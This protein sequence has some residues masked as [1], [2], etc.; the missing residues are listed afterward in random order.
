MPLLPRRQWV[1]VYQH[2][3]KMVRLEVTILVFWGLLNDYW[4]SFGSFV[5]IELCDRLGKASDAAQSAYFDPNR[6]Q[7]AY[8]PPPAY[9]VSCQKL[10]PYPDNDFLLKWYSSIFWFAGATASLPGKRYR[11]KNTMN[12]PTIKGRR[13]NNWQ[14]LWKSF[15]KGDS[16]YHAFSLFPFC[17]YIIRSI[18]Y[19]LQNYSYVL[20]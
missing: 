12:L 3:H 11:Q 4:I 13:K 1:S 6:P 14:H 5:F 9:Y 18:L 17:T 16:N 19:T 15:R 10:L 2:S 7:C 8:V 20:S